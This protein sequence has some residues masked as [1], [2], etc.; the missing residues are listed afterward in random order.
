M[1]RYLF[2]VNWLAGAE[3]R[4]F[5][6]GTPALRHSRVA[7]TP[8]SLQ[9]D[10]LPY[11]GFNQFE[12]VADWQASPPPSAGLQKQS[13]G[14]WA[15]LVFG[16]AILLGFGFG[17]KRNGAAVAALA[18][19]GGSQIRIGEVPTLQKN[20]K[21][22]DPIPQ[23][24]QHK[25]MEL[26]RSGRLYRYNAD[27]AE[28]CEVSQCEKDFAAYTGHKYA[29]GLNSCGSAIYLS[30]MCAGVKPGDKV[31]TNVFTFGAVPSAIIHANA[32]PV[33][34]N[35][36]RGYTIDTEHLARIA[37]TSGAKFCVVSHMRGKVGDMDRIREICQEHGIVM[38]EDC[39]HSLGVC[40]KGVHTGHHGVMA[41]FS[42]QSYKML[43]SGEGGFLVTDDDELAAKAICYA[44]SYEKLYKKHA[45]HP[46]EAVFERVKL[47]IPNFSLRMHAVTAAMIRPQIATLDERIAQYNERY[48]RFAP[49]INSHKNIEVPEQLP[50]VDVVADSIQFNLVDLTQRQVDEFVSVCKLY[51]VPVE[52]F[53]AASNS[54]N[55]KNWQFGPVADGCDESLEILQRAVDLRL[56]LSFEEEDLEIMARVV[57]HA[58]DVASTCG[59]AEDKHAEALPVRVSQLEENVD[60]RLGSLEEAVL[61]LANQVSAL[62]ENISKEA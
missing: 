19:E 11:V 21:T 30:L 14:M 4:F 40:Y 36:T 54:R 8:L 20:I 62:N 49:L 3:P 28:T 2:V 39:A 7:P 10:R 5:D 25:A 53:G 16:A 55:F 60:K 48:F 37:P 17:S 9:T 44:G 13:N 46:P 26:M 24:G 33:Y 42:S 50:D 27:S 59:S 15:P 34:V 45:L 29:V 31:L 18:V 32:E 6:V 12:Y 52:I 47:T 58:A 61:A 56:P 57:L 38:V 43:N 35:T 41:S 51:G 22:P 1:L 23:A